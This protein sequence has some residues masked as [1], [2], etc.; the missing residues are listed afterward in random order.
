MNKMLNIKKRGKLLSIWWFFVIAFVVVGLTAG[1]LI[2]HSADIDIRE[3]EAE[4]LYKKISNCITEQ[5]FLIEEV[6]KED[7]DIFE[8]CKLNEEI[9]G[10]GSVFYFSIQIFDESENLIKEIKGGDFSFERD[11]EVQEEDEEGEKVKAKYYPKCIREKETIW[12]YENNKIREA[13]FEILTASNQLVKKIS[14]I[15]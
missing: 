8:V 4:N 9:F 12:Y 10:E 11:C 1:V 14:A 5:G 3:I 2:Y 7:F 13:S 15:G 6:L